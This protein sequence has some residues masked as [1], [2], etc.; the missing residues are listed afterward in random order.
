V[1]N[2]RKGI[3]QW[4]IKNT[5]YLSVVFSWDL[6]KALKIQEQFKL[7]VI[8]G[9][10]A[11]KLA[12]IE[13]PEPL[14]FSPLHFHNPLATFT[15]RGCPNRCGFCAVPKLEGD[16]RELPSWE[17]KP[18]ICDNNLLAASPKHFDKVIDS[19]KPLPYV[20]FNQGLDAYL[21]TDHHARRMGEL[22]AVCVRFA[23]DSVNDETAVMDAIARARAH[24]L[25]DIGVYVLF[26]FQ[27]TPED[28]KYRLETI[29][30]LGIRP[31]PMRFQPL[32]SQ[33]KNSFVEKGW[34]KKGLE[35]MER[36]Y[37][38]LR[39]LEHIPFEDYR[40]GNYIQQ[41]QLI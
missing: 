2:W 38:R 15:T 25:K 27:D 7:R 26:G 31:N 21:F 36:Y 12:C 11:A 17:I 1:Y 29:R 41:G 6:H 19:L 13:S 33:T 35:D 18:V 23:F 10:P 40:C 39:Y 32:N 28:A 22:K 24:G 3:A 37:A 20:D 4:R 34:T 9:G 30:K 16:F 5:L 8:I 14:P